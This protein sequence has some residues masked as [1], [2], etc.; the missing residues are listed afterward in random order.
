MAVDIIVLSA[1]ILGLL[2]ACGGGFIILNVIGDSVAFISAV[3]FA[4]P[5]AILTLLSA[6]GVS[7]MIPI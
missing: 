4:G 7:I 3:C 2:A 1:A 5:A 6:L